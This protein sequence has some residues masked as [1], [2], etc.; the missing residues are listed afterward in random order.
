MAVPRWIVPCCPSNESEDSSDLCCVTA[1][2]SVTVEGHLVKDACCNDDDCPHPISQDQNDR[3]TH[4]CIGCMAPCCLKAPIPAATPTGYLTE[5]P[6]H[7]VWVIIDRPPQGSFI[8]GIFR[9]P[10]A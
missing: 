9:P 3:P 1:E 4:G 2:S 6:P 5:L 10:R 8:D 7:L